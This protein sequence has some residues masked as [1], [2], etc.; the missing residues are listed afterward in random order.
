[1]A[2]GTPSKK[3]TPE[4][5][6]KTKKTVNSI[7]RGH[8]LDNIIAGDRKRHPTQRLLESLALQ[9]LTQ[10]TKKPKTAP[11]KKKVKRLNT[12]QVT[13]KEGKEYLGAA[14]TPTKRSAEKAKRES[15]RSPGRD[16][17]AKKKSEKSRSRSKSTKSNKSAGDKKK[18]Q[19][20]SPKKVLSRTR[21]M[22]DTIAESK[23]LLKSGKPKGR[24]RSKSA[25]KKK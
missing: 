5:G 1:M 2:K 8:P 14:G 20:K 6:S 25:S 21:T 23:K 10:R 3:D 4:K 11:I 15:A 17:A 16:S 9:K 13:A 12:M 24:T 22:A 19:T 7:V 18:K